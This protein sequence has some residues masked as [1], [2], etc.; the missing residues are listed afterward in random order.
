MSTTISA[1]SQFQM[2]IITFRHH[3]GIE[4]PEDVMTEQKEILAES[5]R[6]DAV[7]VFA[8]GFD[9][10]GLMDRLFPFLGRY[11]VFECKG[12]LDWLMAGQFYQYSLVELGLMAVRHLSEDR[13]DG[14][15]RKWLSQ[16]DA[17]AL[18]RRLKGQGAQNS[19][20]TVILSITDP[21][22]LRQE[23]GLQPVT[24]Y[25]HLSGALYRREILADGFVGSIAV[26]LVVLNA[27]PV[28]AQ[29]AP[30]L[31]LAKGLKQLE[32]CRWL[33]SDAGG[34][35]LE[36]KRL[37]QFYLVQYNL[38]ESEEVR[39]QMKYE[40]FGPPNYDWIFEGIAQKSPEEQERFFQQA[41]ERISMTTS[42]EEVA[43]RLL[44]ATSLEEVAQR[45]LHAD[46][47]EEGAQ[48]LLHV[49]SPVEAALKLLKTPEQLREFLERVQKQDN[50]S[51]AD[52]SH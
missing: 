28:C 21:K 46:S 24:D 47:Q 13:P 7:V 35:T 5:I 39:Q 22:R 6:I 49:D 29:N 34:L 4:R 2:F 23:V 1:D 9:F 17:R 14:K 44:H 10:R 16:K 20:C 15:G 42:P 50:Q 43:Q 48:R 11:N 30:L 12:E 25:P 27:L 8:D 31:L 19:A 3:F 36:E 26:Y 18:W 51:P 38:I 45:L 37:Y 52:S 41:V 32:F 33:L 40:L